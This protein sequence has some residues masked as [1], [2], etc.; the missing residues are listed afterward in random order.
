V[1]GVGL[2]YHHT[3][4]ISRLKSRIIVG[5]SEAIFSKLPNNV[6]ANLRHSRSE[7]ALL[8]NL[9]YPLAQPKL[10]M[11]QLVEIVPQWG[12]VKIELEEDLLEPYFWG[13][14]ISGKRFPGLDEVLQRID[15]DG[16]RTEV[17]LFLMGSSHLVLV[18]AKHLSG[19]GQ[20]SRYSHHRCPEIHQDLNEEIGACR[21]W[22]A[23]DQEFQRLLDF[24]D[25]PNVDESS[26]PCNRHYQL[27]RTLLVGDVLAREHRLEFSL[28]MMVSSTKWRSLER[29]WLDFTKRVRMESLWRRMRVIAWED[30][31]KLNQKNRTM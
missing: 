21:Y 8:W 20:C 23:G 6:L 15:G 27:A 1:G 2:S 30:I 24:G 16:P 26:P 10:S 28:W 25:R 7:N 9:I 12:T 22:E 31:D 13:Y 4:S 19:L 14:S 18:E 11:S 3:H 5:E 29:R 17:D